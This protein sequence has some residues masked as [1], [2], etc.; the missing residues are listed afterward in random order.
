[1]DRCKQHKE[2]CKVLRHVRYSVLGVVVYVSRCI[3]WSDN[4]AL[5]VQDNGKFLDLYLQRVD[6]ISTVEL[7]YTPTSKEYLCNQESGCQESIKM[8][9]V[10][11]CVPTKGCTVQVATRREPGERDKYGRQM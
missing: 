8:N 10:C 7:D 1:M 6:H 4:S 5:H 9:C 2:V 11:Y 3:Y